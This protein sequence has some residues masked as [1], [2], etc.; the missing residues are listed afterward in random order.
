MA[1]VAAPSIIR[2]GS[3]EHHYRLHFQEFGWRER[4]RYFLDS[5]A[6]VINSTLLAVSVM[7]GVCLFCGV[8]AYSFGWLFQDSFT[9]PMEVAFVG[10]LGGMV[11]GVTLSLVSFCWYWSKRWLPELR[12]PS[13][14]F[15]PN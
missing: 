11:P 10:V 3:V 14:D 8:L 6:K 2:T 13:A 5:I 15:S 12:M 9:R 1:L 4:S 7:M